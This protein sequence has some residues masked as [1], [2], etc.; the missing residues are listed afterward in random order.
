[1]DFKSKYDI[2][3]KYKLNCKN[4]YKIKDVMIGG[5]GSMNVILRLFLPEKKYL[6]LK[7]MPQTFYYNVKEEPNFDELEI[8]FYKFFTKKYLLTNRTPNIVGIYGYVH[9]PDIKTF[10]KKYILDKPCPTLTDSL[11][12]SMTVTQE[13]LC[14][15]LLRLE[16]KL[17]KKDFYIMSLE[18][19][20]GDLTKYLEEQVKKVAQHKRPVNDFISDLKKIFFQIIFTLTIIKDDYPGFLHGDFFVRNVLYSLET[21]FKSSDVVAYYYQ[22]LIFYLPANGICAKMNDFGMSIISNVIVPNITDPHADP[23]AINSRN[24]NPFSK[25]TDLFN[26]LFDVHKLLISFTMEFDLEPVL[27]RI[28]GK[29]MNNFID[30]QT[31]DKI[32][33]QDILDDIWHI[34]GIKLLTN[35]LDNPQEYL[36]GSHFNEFKQLNKTYRIIFHYNM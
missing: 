13:I 25:K 20:D 29:F 24:Y 16:M 27:S 6:I 4:K 2:Y 31:L 36:L 10:I 30:I 23:R 17:I 22:D 32:P 12:T 9:C 8:K 26:F 33:M 7:I 35:T 34:D 15:I 5:G 28:L 11:F 14:D 18:N 21:K 3:S 19:C 1:M